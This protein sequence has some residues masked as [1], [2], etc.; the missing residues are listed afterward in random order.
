MDK[1]SIARDKPWKKPQNAELK[2]HG[3]PTSG[4]SWNYHV[5]IGEETNR[6]AFTLQWIKVPAKNNKNH[7]ILDLLQPFKNTD[8][9][10]YQVML[11]IIYKERFKLQPWTRTAFMAIINIINDTTINWLWILTTLSTKTTLPSIFKS[12][13]NQAKSI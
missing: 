3:F 11:V 8:K 1:P 7:G 10:E 6:K 9:N 13:Q 2:E 5:Y 4:R 12:V